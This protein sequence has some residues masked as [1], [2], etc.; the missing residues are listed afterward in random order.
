MSAIW[1]PKNP[2]WMA[3]LEEEDGVSTAPVLG[4]PSA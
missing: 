2:K 1:L 4:L 3:D